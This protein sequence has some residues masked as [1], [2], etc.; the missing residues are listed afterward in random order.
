MNIAAAGVVVLT[1]LFVL[2]V[3]GV[4]HVARDGRRKTDRI[5]LAIHVGEYDYIFT[6]WSPTWFGIGGRP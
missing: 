3:F 6:I 2:H 1:A 4:W 5:I